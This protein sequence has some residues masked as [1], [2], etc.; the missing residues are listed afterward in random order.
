M[1]RDFW[2]WFSGNCFLMDLASPPPRTPF[3]GG[4]VP[5]QMP[6]PTLVAILSLPPSLTCSLMKPP[7]TEL[8]S[9]G[10]SRGRSI[11]ISMM[12]KS[13]LIPILCFTSVPPHLQGM[14]RTV[15]GEHMN[16][17]YCQN[18]QI[19]WLDSVYIFALL[20]LWNCPLLVGWRA[21]WLPYILKLCSPEFAPAM[22]TCTLSFKQIKREVSQ[23]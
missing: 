7:H 22:E 1:L 23:K 8:Y 20:F 11:K 15:M 13:V 4:R 19:Q 10:K 14:H 21:L 9:Q 2:F 5:E 17:G 12:E 6:P 18:V 3:P 16:T